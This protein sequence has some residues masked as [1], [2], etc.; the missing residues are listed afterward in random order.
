[1]E[2]SSPAQCLTRTDSAGSPPSFTGLGGKNT[3]VCP[4]LLSSQFQLCLSLQDTSP[5]NVCHAPICMSKLC[6]NPLPSCPANNHSLA[7]SQVYKWVLQ[8]PIYPWK[9]SLPAGSGLSPEMGNFMILGM[10]DR[11]W[12]QRVPRAWCSELSATEKHG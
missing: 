9:S 6:P 5:M 4:L 12:K 2:M 10:Q 3:H 11:V 7:T 8:R 1:M